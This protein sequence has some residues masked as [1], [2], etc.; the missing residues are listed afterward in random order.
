MVEHRETEA[1]VVEG[2][3]VYAGSIPAPPVGAKLDVAKAALADAE[4]R[5]RGRPST[6]F[7][8]KAYDR[9]KAAERRSKGKE[10]R[11]G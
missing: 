11:D 3:P 1:V 6:G 7:D 2:H 9:Q 5:K 8:K 4:N 10:N